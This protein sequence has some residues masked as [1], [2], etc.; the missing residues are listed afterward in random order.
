MFD[1]WVNA[2]RL[3]GPH[4]W[5]TC[6]LISSRWR[7]GRPRRICAFPPWRCSSCGLITAFSSTTLWN[8]PRHMPLVKGGQSLSRSVSQ[9]CKGRRYNY[10]MVADLVVR[11]LLAVT[12]GALVQ[13]LFLTSLKQAFPSGS[14]SESQESS[15]NILLT[16]FLSL[17]YW[18]LM[19]HH[20]LLG[21]GGGHLVVF[22][23]LKNVSEPFDGTSRGR[24]FY[25]RL[26]VAP[27]ANS[28]VSSPS[29]LLAA[30]VNSSLLETIAG[31]ANL[32]Q[33]NSHH[34]QHWT[35]F[36]CQ[37]RTRYSSWLTDKLRN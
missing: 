24:I 18:T 16:T 34:Q 6:W 31:P 27:S 29:S 10:T 7:P 5:T 17:S 15:L 23:R 33:W 13:I 4:C 12:A 1:H 20:F 26:L 8:I 9:H 30:V 35:R 28:L 2:Q 25:H 3:P 36:M 19:Q 37:R 14:R 22:W 11:L 21:R 32:Q